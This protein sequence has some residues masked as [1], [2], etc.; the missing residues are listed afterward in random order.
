MIHEE[1]HLALKEHNEERAKPCLD[2]LNIPSLKAV[3]RAIHALAPISVE[4]ARKGEAAG[5]KK[6]R[7]AT[8]R[9]QARLS[10][11]CDWHG[12][13]PLKTR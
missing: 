10:N 6:V 9:K 5:R 8:R 1:N 3:R 11:S 7:P 13:A 12:A 4:C 2:A